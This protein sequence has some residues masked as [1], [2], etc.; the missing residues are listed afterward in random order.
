MNSY[1]LI[2][3]IIRDI[4]NNIN[5]KLYKFLFNKFRYFFYYSLIKR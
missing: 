3:L 2:N 5:I 4:I 1:Y